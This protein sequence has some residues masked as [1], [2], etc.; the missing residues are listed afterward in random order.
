MS[1]YAFKMLKKL[2]KNFHNNMYALPSMQL[3]GI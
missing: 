3:H 1:S 2:A